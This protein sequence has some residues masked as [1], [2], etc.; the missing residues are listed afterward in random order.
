MGRRII[1]LQR[2]G[3]RK[4]TPADIA[5]RLNAR[6]AGELACAD[7]AAKFPVLTAENADEAI[8]YQTARERHHMAALSAA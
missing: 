2:A 3:W 1:D 7:R 4:D 6:K 8:E 5:W